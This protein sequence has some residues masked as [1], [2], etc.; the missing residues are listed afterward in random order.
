MIAYSYHITQSGVWS[1]PFIEG[2][3]PILWIEY[4]INVNST[5]MHF[6]DVGMMSCT[7]DVTDLHHTV[8]TGSACQV[9]FW[10]SVKS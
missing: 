8:Y 7:H 3:W 5:Y 2:N 9:M 1:S 10:C 4:F 6:Y